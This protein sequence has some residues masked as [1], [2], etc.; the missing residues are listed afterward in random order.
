MRKVV[1]CLFAALLVVGLPLSALAGTQVF[2]AKDMDVDFWEYRPFW[3]MNK[4]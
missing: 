3:E 1:F 4:I 2:S